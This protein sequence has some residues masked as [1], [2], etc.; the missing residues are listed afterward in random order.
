MKNPF[1][2][3]NSALLIKNMHG[4]YPALLKAIE[5]SQEAGFKDLISLGELIDYYPLDDEILAENRE[6]DHQL[7]IVRGKSSKKA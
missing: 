7:S 6:Y 4:H 2:L 1:E 5:L 3:N